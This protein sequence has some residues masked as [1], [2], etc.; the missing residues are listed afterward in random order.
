MRAS[1]VLALTFLGACASGSESPTA[2]VTISV[3]STGRYPV[4]TVRGEPPLWRL[5]SLAVITPE[6]GVGFSRIQSIAL[7]PSG[8]VWVADVREGFVHR[9][10]DDGNLVETRG[11]MGSGPG[12]F[13]SAYAIASDSGGLILW[14]IQ[15]S[16]TT[17]WHA[18][19]TFD[20]S[21]V[22]MGGR[23]GGGPV[24]WHWRGKVPM[25]YAPA[26][27]RDGGGN[28]DLFFA[29]GVHGRSDTL[30]FHRIPAPPSGL[31]RQCDGASGSIWF[32]SSPFRPQP[33]LTLYGDRAV[34][35][36]G[37]QYE[38]VYVEPL[39]DTVQVVRRVVQPMP[40]TDSMWEEASAE[41]RA[42]TD[43]MA[44]SN[45]SG[46]FLRLP[47]HDMIHDL[48]GDSEGR[49]WVENTS[50]HGRRWDVWRM[51]S[52]LGSVVAPV[53]SDRWGPRPSFLGDRF[54]VVAPGPEG[55]LEVRLFR[56]I[57]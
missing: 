23:S 9:Y 6:P 56:V 48:V 13:L 57:P 37:D 12:E 10:D 47:T 27:R 17:R 28:R 49:L 22:W 30:E 55:G 1:S 19:G 18:D 20:Q 16:R 32:W 35:A 50:V 31:S 11:R 42:D 39:A 43:T 44:L 51:D 8:G 36:A 21:W 34:M 46:E 5:E 25:L 40:V 26:A 3:D 15:N 41:Y 29:M 4:V 14:D 45:C 33:S 53:R 7:D 24:Q 2:D 38:L 54:A 52:L